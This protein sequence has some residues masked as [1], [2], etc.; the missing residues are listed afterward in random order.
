MIYV[1]SDLHGYPLDKFRAFL[2]KSGFTGDDTLWI[3]GDVIDRNGDGGVET[4]R[5][6]MKQKNIKMIMGNHELMMLNCRNIFNKRHTINDILALDEWFENGGA[7]TAET[8]TELKEKDGNAFDEIME[9]VENLPLYAEI[10][11]EGRRFVFVHGGLGDFSPH[12]RLSSYD[13]YDLVWTRLGIDENY[14]KSKTVVLGHTPTKYYGETYR[15]RILK[16]DTWINIDV[17]AAGGADPALLRL[18]DMKEF[19]A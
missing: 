14:F 17:G 7:V 5:W 9:F 13:I 3:L 15:G 4:L 10:D 6:I 19:Y 8:L 2:K 18:D 12:R 16:T 1:C 11:C